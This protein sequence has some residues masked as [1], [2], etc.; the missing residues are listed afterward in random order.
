[1]VE[2]RLLKPEEVKK[3]AQR[4]MRNPSKIG[5]YLSVMRNNSG[6]VLMIME[7]VMGPEITKPRP[8]TTALMEI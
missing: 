4:M 7:P 6:I 2:I 5:S 8:P 3:R 1:M